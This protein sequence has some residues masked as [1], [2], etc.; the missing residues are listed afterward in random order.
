MYYTYTCIQ[1]FAVYADDILISNIITRCDICIGTIP[2]CV[3]RY[4]GYADS[5]LICQPSKQ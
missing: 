1:A 2:I 5:I 3:T 4:I